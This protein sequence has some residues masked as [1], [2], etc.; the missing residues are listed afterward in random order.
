MSEMLILIERC[1]RRQSARE[2]REQATGLIILLI[3]V[4]FCCWCVLPEEQP[5]AGHVDSQSVA[6]VIMLG[7]GENHAPDR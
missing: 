2:A 3:I 7:G 1:K 5:S 4:L 6:T